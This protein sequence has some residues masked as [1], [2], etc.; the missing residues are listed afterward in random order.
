MNDQDTVNR[1]YSDIG[2]YGCVPDG[3]QVFALIPRSG[4]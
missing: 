4:N 1:K 2:G 3:I